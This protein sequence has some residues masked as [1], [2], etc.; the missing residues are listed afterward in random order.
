MNLKIKK[1]NEKDI[2]EFSCLVKRVIY[3]TDYYSSDVKKQEFES[4]YTV[5]LLEKNI[6]NSE[7]Y[8]FL[9]AYDGEKLVGFLH[10]HTQ[11]D[12]F[13]LRWIGVDKDYRHAGVATKIL[14]YLCDSL[15]KKGFHKI[16][17]D[18]N[19]KNIE[20]IL[21]FTELDFQIAFTWKKHWLKE[22]VYI[23]EKFI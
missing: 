17:F 15:K 14:D 5:D 11:W 22:D 7:D 6:S 2:E 8:L 20:A 3:S 13:Y 23:W 16:W 12:V 21:F 10:G 9:G 4:A 19:P 1:I 18:T